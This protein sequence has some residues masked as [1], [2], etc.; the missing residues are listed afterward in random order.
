MRLLFLLYC[1]Y[2]IDY[3][4]HHFDYCY[5]YYDIYL[6]VALRVQTLILFIRKRKLNT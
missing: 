1:M 2:I 6:C 5:Q 4:D 3:I